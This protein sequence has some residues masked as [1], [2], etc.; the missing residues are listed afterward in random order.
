MSADATVVFY[1]VQVEISVA[2]TEA[3]EN[4]QHP[5]MKAAKAAGL[6]TYWADFIPN[7]AAQYEMLVGRR[8]GIFGPEDSIEAHI[9][10]GTVNLTMETVD[11]F[12]VKAGLPSPGKLIVRFHQDQ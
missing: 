8:W 4:R 10:K 5:L 11:A 2:D 7:D 9:E 12:L 3:C 1:G 6:D